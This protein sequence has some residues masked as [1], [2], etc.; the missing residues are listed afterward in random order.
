ME[1]F[2]LNLSNHQ[3]QDILEELNLSV[4]K[5]GYKHKSKENG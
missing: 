1:Q 3:V 4:L 2:L 5:N